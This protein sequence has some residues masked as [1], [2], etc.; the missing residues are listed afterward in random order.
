MSL[1][2]YLPPLLSCVNDKKHRLLIEFEI[3]KRLLC[4]LWLWASLSLSRYEWLVCSA[5]HCFFFFLILLLLL[6]LFLLAH[7]F[8]SAPSFVFFLPHSSVI[9]SFISL[10]LR[11]PTVS[12]H[13]P[14]LSFSLTLSCSRFLYTYPFPL[15]S[16]TI[17]TVSQLHG[18]WSV[19]DWPYLA[20]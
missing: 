4:M 3:V 13:F 15:Y 7:S 5:L 10:S 18:W 16:L 11:L 12:K 19:P 20:S 2:V 1:S 8:S 17:Y 9:P 14:L 6:L